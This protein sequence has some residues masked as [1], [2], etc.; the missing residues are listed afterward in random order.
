MGSLNPIVKILLGILFAGFALPLWLAHEMS[1]SA[2]HQIAR[3]PAYAGHSMPY[4]SFSQELAA[5]GY[6][7]LALSMIWLFCYVTRNR[8][9][10]K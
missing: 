1:L 7:W 6:A 3:D 9:D 8:D 10:H 4:E 5:V 2:A